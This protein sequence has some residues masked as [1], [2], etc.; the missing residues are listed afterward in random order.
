MKLKKVALFGGLLCLNAVALDLFIPSRVNQFKIVF[1]A[2]EKAAAQR[3]QATGMPYN[4]AYIEEA[5][6]RLIAL[7]KAKKESTDQQAKEFGII[8]REVESEC[9]ERLV[10]YARER[11]LTQELYAE[12]ARS[13][14][15]RV[16][17]LEEQQYKSARRLNFEEP[18]Q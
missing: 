12:Y 14:G 18:S 8:I 2:I 15:V 16:V 10:A 11:H 4:L 6:K 9:E 5:N 17:E 7:K 1:D 13:Y 3:V